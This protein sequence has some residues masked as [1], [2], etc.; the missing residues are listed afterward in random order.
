MW[1]RA[2][3]AQAQSESEEDESDGGPP[4]I[5]ADAVASKSPEASQEDRDDGDH[6][7]DPQLARLRDAALLRGEGRQDP[8]EP[9]RRPADGEDELYRSR[10]EAFAVHTGQRCEPSSAVDQSGGATSVASYST[11]VAPHAQLNTAT[12]L[13]IGAGVTK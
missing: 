2:R 1:S 13:G 3:I 4:R 12:L 5:G 11:S 8:V 7:P 6:H 9:E 10:L